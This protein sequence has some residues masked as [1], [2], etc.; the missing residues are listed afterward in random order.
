M[1]LK[2]ER[3][4]RSCTRAARRVVTVNRNYVEYE[5]I[6]QEL[7]IWLLT[8]EERVD[9]WLERGPSGESKLL[10]ALNRAGQYVVKRER[11]AQTGAKKG[12]LFY[13]SPGVI[14][15][16]LPDVWFP[17]QW[18]SGGSMSERGRGQAKPAESGNRRAMMADLRKALNGLP[19][20]DLALLFD[21]FAERPS[22]DGVKFAQSYCLTED[23]LRR[24]LTRIMEKLVDRMGGEPP[25]WR[26]PRKV[27]SNAAAQA[28][29]RREG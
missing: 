25:Q 9:E 5:D 18:D 12:D 14:D 3:I 21:R 15:Q 7:T 13:Y 27:R 26:A 4:T 19:E 1:D 24:R 20:E 8:H 10:K 16:L 6:M 2:D 28:E 22:E 11:E 23:G 29:L 17:E